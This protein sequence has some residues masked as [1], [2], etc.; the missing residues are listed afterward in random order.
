VPRF[1]VVRSPRSRCPKFPVQ[2]IALEDNVVVVM[3]GAFQRM[4]THEV[5]APA[6]ASP[7]SSEDRDVRRINVT[8]RQFV[9]LAGKKRKKTN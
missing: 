4:L 3:G 5:P 7:S 8:L 1:F 9:P 6:P 2:K